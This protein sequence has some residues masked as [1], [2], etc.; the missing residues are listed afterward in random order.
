M[1]IVGGGVW[2]EGRVEMDQLGGDCS[3]LEESRKQAPDGARKMVI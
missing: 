3:G 1:E 2:Q